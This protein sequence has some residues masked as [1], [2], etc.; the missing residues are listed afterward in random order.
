M[1]IFYGSQTGTAEEYSNRL[2]KECQ[3]YGM[4]GAAIDPEECDMEK[5]S[6]LPEM[7]ENHL[8]IFCMATYGEGATMW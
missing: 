4:K 7:I 2:A 8:V 3:R 1:A 5:I 6:I